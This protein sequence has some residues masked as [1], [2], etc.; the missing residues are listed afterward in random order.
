LTN[1]IIDPVYLIWL[2]GSSY[3]RRYFLKS[4]KQTTGIASINMRQLRA[5]P[6]FLADISDQKKFTSI[7]K[8][9]E[10]Q[11]SLHQQ[12]LT[13]QDNLFAS[14]QSRAFNGSL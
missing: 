5:F 3:G 9:I 10:A 14:L 7:I 13:E 4:A 11:K 12:H 6:V 2:I 8:S 1:D